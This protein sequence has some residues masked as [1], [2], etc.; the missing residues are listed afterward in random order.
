MPWADIYIPQTLKVL[1]GVIGLAL[2]GGVAAGV[3]GLLA[4]PVA[5][6]VLFLMVVMIYG[7][8]VFWAY[9]V[10]ILIGYMFAGRGF[11]Y[12][13]FFPAYVG[14]IGIALGIF[15][16]AV[17]PFSNRI[18]ITFKWIV[19]PVIP[20]VAMILIQVFATVPYV[21][22]YE[23]DTLRD[24]MMYLYAIYAILI[25]L[26]IPRAWIESLL[27]NWG[28]VVIAFILWAPFLYV[29]STVIDFPI[30]LPGSPTP[31]VHAKQ[32]DVGVHLGAAAVFILMHL[33]RKGRPWPRWLAWG[34][35]FFWVIG[36]I[37]FASAN[38]ASMLSVLSVIGI[39]MVFRFNRTVWHRPLIIGIIGMWVLLFTGAYSSLQLEGTKGRSI[40]IEQM[41]NNFV[42]IFSSSDS[43]TLDATKEWR[44][45]WWDD[46]IAYTFD[47]DYFWTGKGYGINLADSDGYQV[48]KDGSLRSPHNSHMNFLARSGVPGFLAWVAFLG[49]Y[50]LWLIK[51]VLVRMKSAPWDSKYALWIMAYTAA[52]LI[53]AAVDVVLE[54]PFS[55]IWFWSLVGFSFAYFGTGE[56]DKSPDDPVKEARQTQEMAQAR[57]VREN[58]V[59]YGPNDTTPLKAD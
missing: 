52:I 1:I 53:N 8:R 15:C 47:G 36:W 23:L 46:I 12:V 14:E 29:F 55:A 44:F 31:L 41:V 39:V 58:L 35:W 5:V 30:R 26:L 16:L 25:G 18:R 50:Y 48:S 34:I 59:G 57:L 33:D 51:I 2:T 7:T 3:L 45:N 9:L 27:K 22:T 28:Y 32:G 19:F 49:S 37:L 13:G 20:L 54:S 40:S 17:L 11:A 6:G 21:S 42:S 4:V 43:G 38:R 56:I 24:A 10:F